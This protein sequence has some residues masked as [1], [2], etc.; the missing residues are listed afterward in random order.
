MK[1]YNIDRG[2]VL[3]LKALEWF[4]ENSYDEIYLR[5]FA[6]K[7]RISPNSAQRFLNLFLKESLVNEVKRGN[8]RFFNANLDSVVLRQ[9]KVLFSLRKIEKSG[10][11]EYLIEKNT[12]SFVL[13]GS[14]AKGL[15]DRNSDVD[16]ICISPDKNLKFYE[17][18]KKIGRQIQFHVFT[19]AEWKKQAS[20]NKAFYEEVIKDG[21][22][23]IG[24]KPVV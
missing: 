2:E 4:V 18:E 10:I 23:L 9:I 19:R 7:L 20:T 14:V 5:E 21:L 1:K 11:V 8:L 17:F 6:R 16:F 24:D 15:D 13:F 22:A 3:G 12:T